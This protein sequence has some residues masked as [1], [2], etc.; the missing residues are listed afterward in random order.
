[1]HQLVD[2]NDA[3]LVGE[4]HN[5]KDGGGYGRHA[6]HITMLKDY[7]VIQVSI[8]DLNVYM[9]HLSG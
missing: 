5:A 7:I 2:S 9:D 8:Q 3:I 4:N 1:M 6:I